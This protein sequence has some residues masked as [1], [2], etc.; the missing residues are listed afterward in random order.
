MKMYKFEDKFK[1]DRQSH[2]SLALLILVEQIQAFGRCFGLIMARHNVKP[3]QADNWTELSVKIIPNSR[4][5][6]RCCL[7]LFFCQKCHVKIELILSEK[8]RNAIKYKA[9]ISTSTVVYGEFSKIQF[10]SIGHSGSNLVS[11]NHAKMCMRSQVVA[12]RR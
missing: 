5:Q 9:C 12:K 3:E 10:R 6:W 8:A 1:I 2:S 4:A 11:K 7:H